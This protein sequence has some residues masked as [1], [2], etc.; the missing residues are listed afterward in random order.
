MRREGDGKRTTSTRGDAGTAVVGL[1]KIS[2]V[3]LLNGNVADS[4]GLRR[5]ISECDR[6]GG[7]TAHGLRS[8]LHERCRQG[9]WRLEHDG[10]RAVIDVADRKIQKA[11]VVEIR[12]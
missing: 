7:L 1:G 5:A 10:D 3:A 11:V 4:Q 6:P 12:G 2:A 8:K 9:S